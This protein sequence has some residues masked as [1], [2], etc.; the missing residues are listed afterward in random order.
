MTNLRDGKTLS[1]WPKENE[2]RFNFMVNNYYS[3]WPLDHDDGSSYYNDHHNYFA[4]GGYKTFLGGVATRSHDN[5]Y[6]HPE[7]ASP[8][9]LA[10]LS[11]ERL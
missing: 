3:V 6:I 2:I 9:G 10:S 4:W 5:V 11:S 8:L 7:Y 1:V